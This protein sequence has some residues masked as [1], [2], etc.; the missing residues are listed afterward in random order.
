MNLQN[1]KINII[2]TSAVLLLALVLTI[3]I[4]GR[5]ASFRKFEAEFYTKEADKVEKFH[6]YSKT[7]EGQVA[8]SDIYVFYGNENTIALVRNG[9]EAQYT[10]LDAVK[11][12]TKVAIAT[13]KETIASEKGITGAVVDA[14]SALGGLKNKTY[15]VAIISYGDARSSIKDTCENVMADAEVEKVPSVLVMGGTHPNEPSGQLTATLFLENAGQ[16]VKRGTLYVVNEVNKSAYSHSQPQEAT[17]WY[18]TIPCSDGSTRT[19]KFG[20]RATNTVDQWPTPDVYTHS[21]GQQLSSSEVRNINR[22]YPGSEYGTYTERIAWAITNCIRQNDITM[23][24]DLHEAS[25]EY[26][27]INAIIGHDDAQKIPTEAKM[28]VLDELMDIGLETS[29]QAMRGLTHRELG[30]YTYTYAYL[31]ETSNASQGKIRGAFTDGLITYEKPDKFYEY[32]V[33]LDKE[34]SKKAVA[35]GKSAPSPIIVAKPVSINER[36]ARHTTTIMSLITYF[37][38][39]A[40]GNCMTRET[41][42]MAPDC[43][44]EQREGIYVGAFEFENNFRLNYPTFGELYEGLCEDIGAFLHPGK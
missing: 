32:L 14:Q 41:N 15:N 38:D 35:Q 19:F 4:G 16:Q 43:G 8:D 29:P 34:N 37:N 5:F 30:D 17:S 13:G 23:T 26:V 1:K 44:L 21:S 25:P 42:V 12:E 27:T 36:V 24:I 33:K 6:K 39:P 9:D 28:W 11:A 40:G 20:S 31:C 10:T 2:V 7:L 22:A 3:I 18:Y